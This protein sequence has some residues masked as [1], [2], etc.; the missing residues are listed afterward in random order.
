MIKSI[1]LLTALTAL[2]LALLNV[3][4]FARHHHHHHWHTERLSQTVYVPL[5]KPRPA[6]RQQESRSYEAAMLSHWQSAPAN[7]NAQVFIAFETLYAHTWYTVPCAY[8]GPWWRDK[9]EAKTCMALPQLYVA[10]DA[11]GYAGY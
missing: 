3:T 8:T 10:E 9:A 11:R 7:A 6:Q 5:P 1:A 4:A 2:C